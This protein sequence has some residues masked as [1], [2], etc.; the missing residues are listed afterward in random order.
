MLPEEEWEASVRASEEADLFF[1]IG[2]SAVVYPA[3]SLPWIA[4]RAG[5]YVVE[6]NPEATSLTKDADEFLQGSSG[7]IL[8]ALADE[9]ER[10]RR[11]PS[12]DDRQ[13]RG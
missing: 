4:K 6:I 11:E 13:R 12:T 1:S 5:A 9:M 7:P 2:T 10:C 3:A 8:A